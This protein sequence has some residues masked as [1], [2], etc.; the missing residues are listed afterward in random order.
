MNTSQKLILD[1]LTT[2][3]PLS[4]YPDCN[5][6]DHY[7]FRDT[8]SGYSV[9]YP[10]T[11]YGGLFTT[12]T[13]NDEVSGGSIKKS[14]YQDFCVRE[15]SVLPLRLFCITNL[16]FVLSA[17][18]ESVTNIVKIIYNFG[19]GSP[20]QSVIPDY[21]NAYISP[22]ILPLNHTYYPTDKLVT[23][24]TPTVT[25]L[26]ND[27]CV[28]TYY[29]T[30][31]SYKC[32]IIDAY[33]KAYLLHSRETFNPTNIFLTLES[34]PERQIFNNLLLTDNPLYSIP[35]QF[36]LP[37]IVDPV[38]PEKNIPTTTTT[39][40]AV[41]TQ[42]VFVNPVVAPAPLYNYRE[43]PGINLTPNEVSLLYYELI[44]PTDTSLILS[45]ASL[46]YFASTGILITV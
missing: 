15:I 5:F 21:S 10:T 12:S 6:L 1:Q 43:G 41:T 34:A 19:D 8:L 33:E 20:E 28:A 11:A 25:V 46:P 35:S 45:G 24:Y 38:P 14:C 29:F 31:C 37:N 18:D 22:K 9:Y 4:S 27:S 40:P 17:L 2:I 23:V 32:G 26:Y 30:L 13:F 3:I 7:V 44:T 16:T 39:L 42:P 36:N